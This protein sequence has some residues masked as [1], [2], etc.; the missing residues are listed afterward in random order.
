[1]SKKIAFLFPGQ[2]AQYVGMAKD[3]YDQFNVAKEVFQEADEALSFSLSRLIFEGPFS[4]L[5]LTKNSQL[6]IYV[7]SSAILRAVNSQFPS[8]KPYV[9]AGL[10]LGEYTALYAA[11]KISFKECLMLVKARA[12]YMNEACEKNPGT[13][14]VILGMEAETVEG[15]IS[16]LNPL[17][18]VW[19]AN[20]NCPGQVVIAGSLSGIEAASSVLKEKGAKRILPLDV[21]GAFHSGLMKSA[22]KKLQPLIENIKL[23]ESSILLAMN[24]PGDLVYSSELIQH[25]LIEQVVSPVRWEKAIRAIDANHMDGYLEIGCGKTLTGMN[26]KIGITAPS[27]SIEKVADLEELEKVENYEPIAK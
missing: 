1:M 16:Q 9:C 18:E 22:Q 4:E 23:K 7:A 3:F 2:G 13:M 15:L 20:L 27:F 5:T 21:S 10:S 25:Y 14:R 8:L 11:Q 26:K 6:A 17:H 12:E 19:V 24:T